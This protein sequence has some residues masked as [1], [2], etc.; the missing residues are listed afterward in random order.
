MFK[1]WI[2]DEGPKPPEGW[3]LDAYRGRV[4]LSCLKCKEPL[5]LRDEYLYN[6]SPTGVIVL[7]NTKECSASLIS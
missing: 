7:H 3:G 6:Y 1:L 4:E 5:K 2:S